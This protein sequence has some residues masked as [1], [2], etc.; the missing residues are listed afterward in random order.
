M[1]AYARPEPDACRQTLH[2]TSMCNRR[3][4]PGV[5]GK[6]A[7]L[8]LARVCWRWAQ[9]PVADDRAAE[10]GGIARAPPLCQ[11]CDCAP[12]KGMAPAAPDFPGRRTSFFIPLP[13]R[14]AAPKRADPEPLS[15]S[16]PGRPGPVRKNLAIRMRQPGPAAFATR[17]P[18][19]AST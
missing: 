14:A 9:T 16:A 8:D 4:V 11:R 2:T 15:R 3:A 17:G 7:E 1:Q 13:R 6:A 18:Q 19:P 5:E 12:L 10:P